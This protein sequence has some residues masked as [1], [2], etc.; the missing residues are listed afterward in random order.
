VA[1][2]AL[3]AADSDL[4]RFPTGLVAAL[5]NA[6]PHLAE[7]IGKPVGADALALLEAARGGPVEPALISLLNDLDIVLSVMPDAFYRLLAFPNGIAMIA[8]GVSLWRAARPAADS[9]A[10]SAAPAV[11]VSGR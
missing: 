3:D 6:N 1:W 7:E 9:A 2:L 11:A 5:Q 8:L 4:A 10:A